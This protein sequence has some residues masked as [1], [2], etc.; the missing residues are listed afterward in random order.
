MAV[1]TNG[2]RQIFAALLMLGAWNPLPASAQTREDGIPRVTLEAAVRQALAENR[3]LEAARF[4]LASAR[5]AV[6]EAWSNVFPAVN[7]VSNY[8]RNLEVP[9]NFLPARLFDPTAPEGQLLPVR[10]GSDNVW[11]AQ[12]RL[13]QPVFQAAAFIGVGAAGRY[14][15]LTEET[16]RGLT[17]QVVTRTRMTF[18][19]VLLA[20]ESARL[21]GESVRRVRETL[22][23][24]RA[25]FRAGLASE[26]DVLRMEVELANL[27]PGLRR[28]EDALAAARRSLAVQLGYGS[29][30]PVSA[31]GSL[32]ELDLSS[33]TEGRAETREL[34]ALFGVD[35]VELRDRDGLVEEA[36]RSRSDLRQIRL[37][38]EL[39]LAQLRA[40]QSEYLPQVA[41]FGTWSRT[42]QQ[43]GGPAFFGHGDPLA[44][45]ATG[46]QL[47]LQV[48][49]P[50]FSGFAR[51]ARVDQRRAA[52]RQVEVQERQATEQV[53]NQVLTLR[54][55]VGEAR[56]RAEAQQ[57]AVQQARRGYDI[58]SVQ[59]REGLGSRLELT[60]AEVALRASEFNYAQAVYDYLV[61]R[62]QLD[63]AVGVV[64]GVDA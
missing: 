16:V 46:K 3:E 14:R 29:D 17:H 53:R 2:A 47:G 63:E 39:N 64:P 4:D 34:V 48:T 36:L 25:M 15:A 61:A 26:Y 49:V 38:R 41:F 55:R 44:A 8:T 21:Q 11:Y 58:A 5:G 50:V 40:E 51:P 22:D 32:A 1:T 28:A 60:D 20:E 24:S 59:F 19:D 62:A 54:S 13:E 27:E 23:Q 43:D 42:V 18:L 10:F 30:Q 35:D 45:S 56:E 6:R 31:A 12:A 7:V 9:V 37:T 33:P 57:R 52:V